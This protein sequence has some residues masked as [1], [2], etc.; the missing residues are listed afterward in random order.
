MTQWIPSGTTDQYVYF[1]AAPG[2]PVGSLTVRVARQTTTFT[3]MTT[4]S[5]T[6]I[7]SDGDYAL[8]MNQFTTTTAGNLTE[9]V[10]VKVL[11]GSIVRARFDFTIF[12]PND[13]DV[14]LAANAVNSTSIA[15]SAITNTKIANGA[16][17]AGK[18]GSGAINS[19]VLA[20]NA[21]TNNVLDSTAA[22]EIAVRVW[23]EILGNSNYS[24]SALMQIMA[25][26]LAGK[27]SGA[28]TATITIRSIEDD[29]NIIVAT[30][31]ANGNRPVVSITTPGD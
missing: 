2:L 29:A 30:V 20:N 3:S 8:L 22:D 9:S 5:I 23:T 21:I 27:L 1:S 26:A 4:P 13:W 10:R 16:I 14:T 17:S 7:D 24:A 15:A 25:G 6:E 19:S 18:F 28:G 11:E 31:D 12:D